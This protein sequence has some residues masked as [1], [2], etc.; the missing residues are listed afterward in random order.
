MFLKQKC[1]FLLAIV[2]ICCAGLQC[3]TMAQPPEP[4]DPGPKDY[5]LGIKFLVIL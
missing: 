4:P 2:G 1:C 5:S 3:K